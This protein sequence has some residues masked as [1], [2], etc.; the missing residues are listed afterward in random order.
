[1]GI[2]WFLAIIGA[3]VVGNIGLT[4]KVNFRLG[5]VLATQEDHDRRISKLEEKNHGDKSNEANT[6]GAGGP[7][8]RAGPGRGHLHITS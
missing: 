3:L 6:R 8:G 7:A 1:M 4:Y 5:L 2:E